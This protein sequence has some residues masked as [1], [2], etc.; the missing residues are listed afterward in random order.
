M[1]TTLSTL[2]NGEMLYLARGENIRDFTNLLLSKDEKATFILTPTVSDIEGYSKSPPG[3]FYV[4]LPSI[5]KGMK[6]RHLVCQNCC[7]KNLNDGQSGQR[8]T[9]ARDLYNENK[10]WW[11]PKRDGD[12]WSFQYNCEL[13]DGPPLFLGV[14]R[15]EEGWIPSL[16][17]NPV[18]WI[19]PCIDEAIRKIAYG[20]WMKYGREDELANWIAAERLCLTALGRPALKK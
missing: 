13:I 9:V 15:G 18:S 12:G 14:K 5:K 7:L 11:I 10:R 6:T 16:T 8:V 3:S 17:K 1:E 19:V 2:V 4:E 20:I